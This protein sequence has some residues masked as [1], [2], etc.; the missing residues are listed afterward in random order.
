MPRYAKRT[1]DNH[2][3]V[4]EELRSVLPDGTVLDASGAG[5]GFLA[6]ADSCL[7]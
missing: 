4:V 5:Q 1:D 7:P 6:G 3:E 2:S